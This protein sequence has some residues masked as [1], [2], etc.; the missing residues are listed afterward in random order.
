MWL[1]AAA[2]L[3]STV[4]D[5]SNSTCVLPHHLSNLEL[6]PDLA[7]HGRHVG[8]RPA[9]R[10]RCCDAQLQTLAD[11]GHLLL[12]ERHRR[13]I[14]DSSHQPAPRALPTDQHGRHP[15]EPQPREW[16]SRVDGGHRGDV[17]SVCRTVDGKEGRSRGAPCDHEAARRQCL[18]EGRRTSLL[19]GSTASLQ[20]WPGCATSAGSHDPDASAAAR[21]AVRTPAS[22]FVRYSRPSAWSP[23]ADSACAA[24]SRDDMSDDEARSIFTGSAKVSRVAAPR[25]WTSGQVARS[26]VEPG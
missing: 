22:I 2:M 19:R 10:L 23:D 8:A 14:Q 1:M 21:V 12:G 17:H 11:S 6:H 5:R 13:Q 15:V 9:D 16:A 18:R 24:S 4:S 20:R 25:A 3:P 26:A 7:E